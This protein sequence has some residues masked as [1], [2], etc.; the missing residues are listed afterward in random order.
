[1]LYPMPLMGPISGDMSMAP[2]ITAVEFM[3]RPTEATTMA[4]T[5]IHRLVPL[6]MESLTMLS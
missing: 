6:N 3:F 5:R 1:M 4:K 2:M